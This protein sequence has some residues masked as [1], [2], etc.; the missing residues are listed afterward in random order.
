MNGNRIPVIYTQGAFKNKIDGML[1]SVKNGKI[2]FEANKKTHT[3][4]NKNVDFFNASG[5]PVR[6]IWLNK[7]RTGFFTP[8]RPNKVLDPGQVLYI[9]A[10]NSRRNNNAKKIGSRLSPQQAVRESSLG[11]EAKKRLNAQQ[12]VR[13]STNN[14]RRIEAEKRRNAEKKMLNAIRRAKNLSQTLKER[15]TSAEET[16]YLKIKRGY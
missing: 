9:I 8:S 5:N 14:N 12:A 13:G 1:Y 4:E 16:E 10:S 7:K 15:M 11:T 3:K 6:I 2:T